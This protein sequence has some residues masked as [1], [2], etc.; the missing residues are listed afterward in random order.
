MEK[1]DGKQIELD[2]TT[3]KAFCECEPSLGGSG[4]KPVYVQPKTQLTFSDR[5]R[6]AGFYRRAYPDGDIIGSVIM[7]CGDYWL[8]FWCEE[9]GH[10]VFRLRGCNSRRFCPTCADK[11]KRL[12]SSHALD[13][14]KGLTSVYS[15]RIYLIHVVIT[16]P[17]ELWGEVAKD[18]DKAFDLV[19]RLFRYSGGG[20]SGG[21]VAL[22]L[23]HTSAPLSG[24][25]PHFHV[26]VPNVVIRRGGCGDYL[27]RVRPYFN[28]DLFK[29]R[30]KSELL[31]TYNFRADEV[32]V[33]FEYCR[34]D[35]FARAK[36]L[37]NYAFRLPIEDLY[38]YL[39]GGLSEAEVQFARYL[40]DFKG[41]R[42]RWFGFLADGV[43][44]RYVKA[45]IRFDEWFKKYGNLCPIHHTKLKLLEKWLDRPPPN[46]VCLNVM[47]KC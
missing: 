13:V 21:V 32:D 3:I 43:K 46:A 33:Y 28:L 17:K 42:I 41:H 36:H 1:E 40:L 45:F 2:G 37:L 19:Y 25:F 18:V 31:M 20:I 39:H 4:H 14:F 24:L 8:K 12:K 15:G 27:Q 9:G 35:N 22:H 5:E 11:Y 26:I 38:P 7:G 23:W 16:F 44:S 30:F 29:W 34:L 47:R 10:F 6:L